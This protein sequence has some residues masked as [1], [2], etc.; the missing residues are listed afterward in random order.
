MNEILKKI[1]FQKKILGKYIINGDNISPYFFKFNYNKMELN[2][3]YS[4]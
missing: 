3:N 4:K 1:N 2:K